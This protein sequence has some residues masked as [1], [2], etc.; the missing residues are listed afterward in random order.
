MHLQNALMIS[1]LYICFG[2][3]VL[4][5]LMAY[6]ALTIPIIATY[7]YKS[8]KGFWNVKYMHLLTGHLNL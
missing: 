6:L 4:R 3:L 2:V 7:L 1:D 8:Q 5:D